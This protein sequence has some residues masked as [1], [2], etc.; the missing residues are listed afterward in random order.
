MVVAE[1]AIESEQ[2][3]TNA[4][5][6]CKKTESPEKHYFVH[7]DQHWIIR[8]SDETNILGYF[9]IEPKRH[10]LDLSE[11]T[12]EELH[13]Y[14][15]LLSAL[16]KAIRSTVDAERIYTFSLGE[17]MP[18]YHLHVVPRKVNFPRTYKARG[19]MQYPLTPGPSPE[20]VRSVCDRVSN[21]L[22]RA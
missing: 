1:K 8:H 22:R 2:K 5:T 3:Q 6:I 7:Q 15:E 17:S 16:M 12:T 21:I 20:L 9:I 13:R 10:I 11:A 4:C 18:H 19:I 14:G